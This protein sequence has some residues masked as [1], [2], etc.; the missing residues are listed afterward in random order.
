[1]NPLVQSLARLI[2]RPLKRHLLFCMRILAIAAMIVPSAT[3]ADAGTV[4]VS[5]AASLT[6]AIGDLAAAYRAANPGD[7]VVPNL[8]ASGTLAKQ[9][10]A[11]AP[12]DILLSASTEWLD[13][14]KA[15]NL[16]ARSFPLT[17]NSLVFVGSPKTVAAGMKDLPALSRIALG[18]PASVPS[19]RYASEA[20]KVAGIEKAL[21][22]KAVFTKDVREALMYAERGEVDGAFVF[23]TDAL[24]ARNAGTLFEVPASLHS[25]IIYPAILT[26]DGAKNPAAVRFFE[27]LSSGPA[28]AILKSRGF[29]PPEH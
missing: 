29:T 11:G 18:S 2:S 9:V 27:F 24:V 7:D 26:N 16:V 10:E 25:D 19:G 8:G 22:G 4:R 20:M 3:S 5:A 23:K 12:A 1:M 21:E 15:R 17:K 6:E 14:M 28:K 13:Y